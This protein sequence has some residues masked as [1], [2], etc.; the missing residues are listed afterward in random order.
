MATSRQRMEAAIAHRDP[1]VVPLDLGGTEVTGMHVDTVYN[2]RQAL[3]LDPPGT[4][5][6]LTEPYQFLAEITDDLRDALGIDT[7]PLW[8]PGNIFGFRNEDWKEWRTFAGTPVLVPGKFNTTPE[9]DGEI[10]QYPRGDLNASASARMPKN[11]FY[12][13]SI[14]RQDPI[15]DDNLNVQDNLEEFVSISDEDLEFLGVEIE[16]LTKT[17]RAIIGD[18]GGS[19]FGDA[20]LVPGMELAHPKGIRAIDEWYMSLNMRTDYI[21]E[22]FEGQCAVAISN[23]AKVHKVVG[24][25]LTAVVVSTTDFGAQ[26]GPLVGPKTYRNLFAPFHRKVNDWIHE[27]TSWKTFMHCCGSISRLL[28]D[29]VD[30]GFDC[31]NPVQTSCT[32]MDPAE[33]KARFGD[34]ITFWGGGIDTQRVL[35]FGTPDEVR[36]MVRDRINI[37]GESGGFVYAPIHNVQASVPT[38]NLLAMYEAVAKYRDRSSV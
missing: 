30:A 14:I 3:S 11:G 34:R 15:D 32:G 12:F 1:D 13:D 5:V 6:K 17:D 10:R 37:F 25:R 7:V 16:R 31:L 36:A 21:Y 28:D 35:P 27:N 2:L 22:L 33:L 18:F 19:S 20:A 23:L 4:P 8:T 26:E 38:E 24:D 9:P 29:I